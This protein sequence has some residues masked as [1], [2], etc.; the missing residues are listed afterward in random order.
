[1]LTDKDLIKIIIKERMAIYHLVTLTQKKYNCFEIYDEVTNKTL[2]FNANSLEEAETKSEK[3]DFSNYK[4]GE[5]VYI[6]DT[7]C[8]TCGD[9]WDF[10]E[11]T[12]SPICG[13]CN[14]EIKER[15]N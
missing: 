9:L 10:T 1:M 15:A 11:E 6:N 14:E 12:G 2:Y 4:D 8:S 3:I 7:L 5:K 13:N